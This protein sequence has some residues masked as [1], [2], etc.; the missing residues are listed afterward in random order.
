MSL[1]AV[2]VVDTDTNTTLITIPVGIQPQ[3]ITFSPDGRYAYV[4][5]EGSNWV[6]VIDTET[7]SVVERISVGHSPI[8]I[9][10]THVSHAGGN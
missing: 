8:G 6:A 7:L 1:N 9:A 5:A 2:A 4:V 10:I 3:Y